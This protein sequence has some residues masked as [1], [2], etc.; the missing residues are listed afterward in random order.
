MFAENTEYTV[1]T[2]PF[3]TYTAGRSTWTS[4]IPGVTISVFFSNSLGLH[5]S[6]PFH[7]QLFQSSTYKNYCEHPD[8]NSSDN[9]S[10]TIL[11]NKGLSTDP[12]WIPTFTTNSLL[13]LPLT[14]NPTCWILVHS[15]H[16]HSSTSNLGIAHHTKS[17][18]SLSKAFS[19]S[20]NAKYYFFF[21][22]KYIL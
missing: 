11:K 12:W 20:T 16:N 10:R 21:L 6:F 22:H 17:H 14:L 8:L 18:G 15:L 7:N 3:P 5:T 2:N 9:V 1:A 19:K 13:T 4:Y